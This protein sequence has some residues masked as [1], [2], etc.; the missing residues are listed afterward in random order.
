MRPRRIFSIVGRQIFRLAGAVV[1]MT[2]LGS[3]APAGAENADL[4]PDPLATLVR[5][6]LGKP[7]AKTNTEAAIVTEEAR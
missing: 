3:A 4:R 5:K 1:I 6:G 7:P 2:I